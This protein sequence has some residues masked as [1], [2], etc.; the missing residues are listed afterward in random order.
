MSRPEPVFDKLLEEVAT[1]NPSRQIH[2]S[3]VIGLASWSAFALLAVW[4]GSRPMTLELKGAG[5]LAAGEG[6]RL[7]APAIRKGAASFIRPGQEA[8]VELMGTGVDGVVV[9]RGDSAAIELRRPAPEG[10]R[11]G[12]YS[13]TLWKGSFFQLILASRR[14]LP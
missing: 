1:G 12:V 9:A 7:F 4:A 3:I 5:S 13:V 8:R 6:G 11:E 2:R 14:T 10:A